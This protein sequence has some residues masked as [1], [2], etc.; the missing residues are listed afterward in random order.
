MPR[1]IAAGII[2]PSTHADVTYLPFF[3]TLL[4][5][6][7]GP[8]SFEDHTVLRYPLILWPQHNFDFGLQDG[9]LVV[10]EE[11]VRASRVPEL[12]PIERSVA[13]ASVTVG[14]HTAEDVAAMLGLPDSDHS[15]YPDQTWTYA[16][17]SSERFVIDLFYGLVYHTAVEQ[18]ASRSA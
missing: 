8:P 2:R 13:S 6:F 12:Q 11:F 17:P 15:W 3:S 9:E 14:L 7:F 16:L 4:R 10:L 1:A 18:S 5:S